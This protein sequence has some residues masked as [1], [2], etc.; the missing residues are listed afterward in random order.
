VH[1]YLISIDH[2]SKT[3]NDEMGI[4]IVKTIVN[5]LVKVHQRPIW[6]DYKIIE[7]HEAKDRH[8]HRWIKIILNC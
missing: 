8:I 1:E 6:D 7:T 4:R 3:S 2:D 5:E